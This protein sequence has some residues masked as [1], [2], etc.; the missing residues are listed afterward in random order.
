M[1]YHRPDAV[2]QASFCHTQSFNI[3]TKHEMPNHHTK[4]RPN[5]SHN[6]NIVEVKQRQ[7]EVPSYASNKRHRDLTSAGA[8]DNDTTSIWRNVFESARTLLTVTAITSY[9]IST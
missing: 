4:T 7:I 9:L 8:N 6:H 3:H 2:D 5:R 1:E